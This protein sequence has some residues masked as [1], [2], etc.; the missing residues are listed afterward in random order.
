MPATCADAVLGRF[1]PCNSYPGA[2]YRR[3]RGR[4]EGKKAVKA[5]THYPARLVYRLLTKGQE[6][7][8][9]GAAYF[10]NK[11]TQRDIIGITRKAAQLGMKL[12]PGS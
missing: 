1:L 8:D 6:Y 2:R 11:R 7:I 12:V 10:E 4:M 3:M 9:R 5:M